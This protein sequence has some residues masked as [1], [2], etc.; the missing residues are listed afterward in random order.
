MY[1]DIEG[2]VKAINNRTGETAVVNFYRR[3]WT[4]NSS[5]D[6]KIYDGQGNERA[7]L[8]G[9]WWDQITF[10]DLE[11]GEEVLLWKEAAAVEDANRMFGFSKIAISL[12]YLTDEMKA[13]LPP[14]DTRLRGDQRL[15]EQGK[16][17]EADAEKI[18]LEVKQRQA[19]KLREES[20]GVFTP[21]FFRE[22]SHPHLEGEKRYE[23]RS[24]NCYWDRRERRDWSGQLDPW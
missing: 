1:I 21:S 17:D 14:T 16:V 10:V 13:C 6:A 8:K 12:N 19:R 23:Y 3:G 18:R 5:I 20:G 22:T 7:H 2:E 4:T 24:D 15:F 9:S 11:T